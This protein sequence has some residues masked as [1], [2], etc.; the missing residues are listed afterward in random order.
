MKK[1]EII[2]RIVAEAVNPNWQGAKADDSRNAW[3]RELK[4]KTKSEQIEAGEKD[5]MFN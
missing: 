5:R 3:R 4:E 1:S 2:E